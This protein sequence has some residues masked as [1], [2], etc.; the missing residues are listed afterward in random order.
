MLSW[1]ARILQLPDGARLQTEIIGREQASDTEYPVYALSAGAADLPP[2]V[3]AA[4]V[5]GDE[6]ETTEA[7]LRLLEEV[8]H[9]TTPLPQRRLVV[10][11]CLNPSGMEAGTRANASGQDIN[12]QFH[13]DL[14]PV[15][16]AVRRFLTA[17]GA[18]ALVDLHADRSSGGFYFFELLQRSQES[19]APAVQRGMIEAGYGLEETPFYAGRLGAHG[20]IAPTPTQIE[21]FERMAPGA[22]LAQWAWQIGVPR[23][24]VFETPQ[25]AGA[26]T[27]VEMHLTA[28]RALFGAVGGGA[29]AD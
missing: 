22:S 7:A 2:L 8:V 23:S 1:E 24:Y 15:T 16:A 11:P 13:A 9:G 14:T 6:P 10:L 4:G 12:R 27:G 3:V 26:E 20:L 21:E 28:L 18:A 19:L 17:I 29:T 25:G 5:H